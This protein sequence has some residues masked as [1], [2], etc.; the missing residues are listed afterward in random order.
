MSS[1][2]WVLYRVSLFYGVR[3]L[4]PFCVPHGVE[5]LCHIRI[6][7]NGPAASGQRALFERMKGD[8]FLETNWRVCSATCSGVMSVF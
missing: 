3:G 5:I 1:H 4:Y 2:Q 6:K 7:T 8:Y